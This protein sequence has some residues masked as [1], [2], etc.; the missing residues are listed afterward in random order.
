MNDRTSLV[1]PWLVLKS[2]P[3][4]GNLLFKRLIDHFGSPQNVLAA[5][6]ASLCG[7][8]GIGSS[9]AA[10]IRSCRTLPLI[11]LEVQKALEKGCRLITLQDPEYPPLLAQISD[12]PP[13]LYTLGRISDLG[14]TVAVV[15]SRNA[16]PYGHRITREL[17]VALAQRGIT[18]VSGMARG[19]D[20]SAHSAA[21]EG[22]GRTVA[23][24][25]AGL[26]NIYP[27]ENRAL[28]RRIIATG[29]AITEF[30]MDAQPEPHHFPLRNRIISGMSL[31]T[32]VVEAGQ[33]SG[34][35]ITARLAAEQNREVFAVP[36]SIHAPTARGTHDLIKQGAKLVETVDD[37]LEEISTHWESPKTSVSLSAADVSADSSKRPELSE[38]EQQLLALIGPY[39]IHIDEL[40]RRHKL[41]AGQLAHTLSLL[42][43]KGI[44]CQE[45]GKFFIRHKDYKELL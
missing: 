22:G 34:S 39:P 27:G 24:L 5:T 18:I 23:V 33:R 21:L 11:T 29:A 44:V 12:P 43:L 19:I 45:P 41:P 30:P 6:H 40:V 15:G 42:E 35:L 4:I 7:V 16:T 31:G 28:C 3:G 10:A 9:L 38:T 1:A 17:C 13:V 32:V 37:I 2:V 36:G 25:G 20:S 8:E 14:P 26:N